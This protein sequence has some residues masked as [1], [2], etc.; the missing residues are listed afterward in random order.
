VL[1]EQHPKFF[2][3]IFGLTTLLICLS[4]AGFPPE[5]TPGATATSSP[6]PASGDASAPSLRRN[7]LLLHTGTPVFPPD[8]TIYTDQ[9]QHPHSTFPPLNTTRAYSDHHQGASAVNIS[10][11]LAPIII[12]APFPII[13]TAL[14]LIIISRLIRPLSVQTSNSGQ[15]P[16]NN[17][18]KSSDHEQ[19]TIV[20]QQQAL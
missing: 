5:A 4:C 10:A 17:R 15:N 16:D 14:A 7:I 2:T 11:A 12:R 6:L 8:K 19:T 13:N 3:Q 18:S 1:A 20:F 9:G